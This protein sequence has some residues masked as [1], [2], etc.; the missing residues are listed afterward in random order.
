MHGNQWVLAH[1]LLA[2]RFFVDCSDSDLCQKC[3]NLTPPSRMIIY[4][5]SDKSLK[6]YLLTSCVRFT[7]DGVGRDLVVDFLQ[8]V[9]LSFQS[10][11]EVKTKNICKLANANVLKD[12]IQRI[13]DIYSCTSTHQTIYNDS[14][15]LH[16]LG[17]CLAV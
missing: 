16:L 4:F 3:P 9:G 13:P 2:T 15:P 17:T 10:I 8:A 11:L 7:Y 5:K 1:S 6:K 12:V 14:F